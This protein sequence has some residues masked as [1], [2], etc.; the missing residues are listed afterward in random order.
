VNEDSVATNYNSVGASIME[1]IY[2][3]HYLSPGGESATATLA[4][5]GR[6]ERGAKVLDVGSGLG[7]AAFYLARQLDCV[8]QGIDI[9]AETVEGALQRASDSGLADQ[10]RFVCGDAT[11]LPFTDRTYSVIW[12]QDAW[13]HIDDKDKLAQEFARVLTADGK[14]VFS[15]WLLGEPAGEM[16]ESIRRVTASPFMA[17]VHSY[18][19]ILQRH[20]FEVTDYADNSVA[21]TQ[22]YLGII[23]RLRDSAETLRERF[24]DRVFDKVL[25][26]QEAVLG[27]FESGA[28][29]FGLFVAQ[30][31]S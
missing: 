19:Q 8:V 10:V 30:R 2:G 26:K 17:D 21:F 25:S 4:T 23:E 16:N 31:Q 24:S 1:L 20:G 15:D 22:Q 9:V 11:T 29:K 13:C 12:G 28:L 6:I 3:N 27:A 14:L 18:E 7:G 5:F